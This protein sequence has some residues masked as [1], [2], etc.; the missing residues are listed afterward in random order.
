MCFTLAYLA[1]RSNQPLLA[2]LAIGSLIFKPQLGLA[3]AVVFV[4]AREWRVVAGAVVA[5]SI[6]L[7]AAWMLYGSEVMRTYFHALM[8]LGEV[9]PLL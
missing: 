6:Q 9:L 8:H 7:A 1:L 2:G 5:G 3:A 4:F